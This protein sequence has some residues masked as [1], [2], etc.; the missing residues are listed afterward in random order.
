MQIVKAALA[1]LLCLC[2]NPVGAYAAGDAGI[3]TEIPA[4]DAGASGL[5]DRLEA[6]LSGDRLVEAQILLDGLS[7]RDD[8][9]LSELAPLAA[10][11]ALAAGDL[12]KAREIMR[13][14]G[15]ENAGNCRSRISRGLISA[16]A[17]A[18]D[19]AIA[20]L[21]SAAN[22]CTLD[23]ASWQALGAMLAERKDVAASVY[24]FRRALNA[25]GNRAGVPAAFGHA[26]LGL[27]QY[28]EARKA[29]T[30]ALMR[31]PD[32]RQARDDLDILSGVTGEEPVRQQGDGDSR[33]AQRLGNAA[34]GARRGGDG[35]RA[36]AL[37]AR[38]LMAAPVYDPVLFAQASAR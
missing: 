35:E 12:P 13:D 2:L 34:L 3:E 32:N 9:P 16:A 28:D 5:M 7:K 19:E 37:S 4:S 23:A 1:T 8:A 18:A 21:G 36:K 11:L 22:D 33:W 31:D 10:R 25:P 20:D 26:M 30:A 6:A 14:A 27:G 38:A 24:A 15:R 17:M 29:L